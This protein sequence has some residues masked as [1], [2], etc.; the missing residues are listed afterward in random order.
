MPTSENAPTPQRP[1]DEGEA[2]GK[3]ELN[4][5]TLRDLDA[6]ADEA[7]KGGAII[8]ILTTDCYSVQVCI[9]DNCT[10]RR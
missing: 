5:D 3:L 9:T 7:V 4:R 2:A 6:P 1:A 8:P 10:I